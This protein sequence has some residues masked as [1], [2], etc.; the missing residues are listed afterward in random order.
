MDFKYSLIARSCNLHGHTVHIIE[1]STGIEINI[2]DCPD[3]ENGYFQDD[4]ICDTKYTVKLSDKIEEE[5]KTTNTLSADT[6][7]VKE[8][9]QRMN[10][11]ANKVLRLKR[12]IDGAPGA[13]NPV[14]KTIA[15]KWSTDGNIWYNIEDMFHLELLAGIA[16]ESWSNQKT[17]ILENIIKLNGSEPLAHELYRE[18]WV[19]SQSNP[20]S[21]LVIGVAAAEVG[22]KKFTIELVPDTEWLLANIQSPPLKLM[23]ERYLPLIPVRNRI[24]GKDPFIPPKM[25]KD[26]EKAVTIR[27]EIVH[28]KRGTVEFKVVGPILMTIRHFLYLLDYYAGKDWAR[29]ILGGRSKLYELE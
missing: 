25:L 5:A 11:F 14:R 21:A 23:I 19:E 24:N 28:G 7:Q 22:F 8:V 13:P 2:R 15:A 17:T 9:I 3:T 6:P 10:K 16:W 12:W 29:R 26:L 1:D 27:N 20:R 18:A 4:A